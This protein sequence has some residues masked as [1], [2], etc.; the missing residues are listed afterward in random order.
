MNPFKNDPVLDR[1]YRLGYTDR[2]TNR[3][4]TIVAGGDRPD[5]KAYL[6]GWSDADAELKNPKNI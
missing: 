2:Q 5:Q 4:K 6:Q 3:P 1:I